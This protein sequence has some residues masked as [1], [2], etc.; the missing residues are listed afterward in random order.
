MRLSKVDLSSL[1][2]IAHSDGYLQLLLDRGKELEFLEIP[3]PIQAY[4][5]LQ[6][7]NEAI[8]ETTALPFEEEPIGMLPVSSSMAAAVGYD[9]DE[10]ILQVE[11]QNGAIYQYLGVDEDTWEDLHASDSIGSFFNQEI[12][13]RYECDRIDGNDY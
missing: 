5:G 12:K 13:G 7:L 1:V 11:F 4:E 6:E 10:Q 3:A 8:A 2:A 9:P